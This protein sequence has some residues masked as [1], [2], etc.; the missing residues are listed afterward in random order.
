[1][2]GGIRSGLSDQLP[3]PS[4]GIIGVARFTERIEF[5]GY[6]GEIEGRARWERMADQHLNPLDWWN[7]KMVGFRFEGPVRFEEIIA[8]RGRQ[9]FFELVED[10]T[11][12]VISAAK[13]DTHGSTTGSTMQAHRL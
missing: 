10:V 4:R 7:E 5:C 2:E 12:A 1:M 9:G 8:C 11:A 6:L 3:S 13:G